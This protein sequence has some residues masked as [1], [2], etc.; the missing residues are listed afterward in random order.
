MTALR[1]I[2]V[3]AALFIV[4]MLALATPWY[5]VVAGQQVSQPLASTNNL[6]CS[7]NQPYTCKITTTPSSTSTCSYSNQQPYT[8]TIT[9]TTSLCS[10]NQPY[11][12][13]TITTSTGIPTGVVE[14]FVFMETVRSPCSNNNC[15]QYV[16]AQLAIFATDN[17]IYF[18]QITQPPC[19]NQQVSC[20]PPQIALP[21]K[22]HSLKFMAH[23]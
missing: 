20:L 13:K 11:T 15:P 18:I 16:L 5:A 22:D 2:A 6:P 14:G 3:S 19:S 8:C 21:P 17:R 12:C 7:P 10:P 4:A 9:A 1:N 23:S